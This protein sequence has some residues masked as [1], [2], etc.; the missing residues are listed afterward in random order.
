MIAGTQDFNLLF[1]E[2]RWRP[3]QER[4]QWDV[5]TISKQTMERPL[6]AQLVCFVFQLPTCI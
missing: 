3:C 1:V 5:R 4:R 6:L 2:C